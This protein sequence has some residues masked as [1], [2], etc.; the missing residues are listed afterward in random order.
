M[1]SDLA[2]WNT[3]KKVLADAGLGD[4]K[5][6]PGNCVTRMWER[7][8]WWPLKLDSSNWRKAITQFSCQR[9]VSNVTDSE[10]TD[11]LGPKVQIRQV[12]LDAFR[13]SFLCKAKN[14]E[15]EYK[16]KGKRRKS[17]VPCTV[18]GKGFNK[19]EDLAEVRANDLKVEAKAQAKVHTPS[20]MHASKHMHT[21]QRPTC[22]A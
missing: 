22:T 18:F 17:S 14:M 16:K 12:V 2:S 15:E 10:L 21:P 4:P 7:T 8:G 9:D 6:K 3:K 19:A 5:G 1:Q 11:E 13:N 20:H